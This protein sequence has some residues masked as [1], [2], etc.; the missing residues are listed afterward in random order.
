MRALTKASIQG[1]FGR[2]PGGPHLYRNLTR[3]RMGT[4]GSHID[5][6]ARAW[7]G[8]V[9]TWARYG[10]GLEGKHL[11]MHDGAWTPY[12]FL[13][14]YLLTGHGGTATMWEGELEDRYT[15]K[16][17]EF[18]L[19]QRFVGVE[20]PESRFERLRSLQG[21]GAKELVLALGGVWLR[22]DRVRPQLEPGSVDLLLTGGVLEH[23]RPDELDGF[24]SQSRV[25][26]RSR[27][28][29]SHVFDLRDHLYHADK[30]LPFLNHLRFSDRAY[31]LLFGH[32]LGYHNRLLPHELR[33]AVERA[34]FEVVAMRRRIL[35]AEKYA[36]SPEEFQGALVGLER[37]QL[38]TRFQGATYEDLRTV[39]VQFLCRVR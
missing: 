29:A 6:L 32:R 13:L 33:A 11:W 14:M 23:F 16:A 19:R 20:I 8:Y 36:E 12:P 38:A 35:P 15:A 7:P 18:G 10:L 27:A 26:L 2:L 28:W 30:S 1:L 34:G 5:K 39:A 4:Q 3:A 24:L 22:A 25:V 17:I 31:N 21:V 9:E 37:D